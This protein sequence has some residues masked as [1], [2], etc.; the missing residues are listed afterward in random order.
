MNGSTDTKGLHAAITHAV[1]HY[2][3]I[4]HYLVT[5]Q[6]YGIYKKLFDTNKGVMYDF[7]QALKG[8]REWNKSQIDSVVDDIL[9]NIDWTKEDFDNLI[10]AIFVGYSQML[11]SVNLK[12][13]PENFV[14]RVPSHETFLHT[15]MVLSAE[16]IFKNPFIFNGSNDEKVCACY[17]HVEQIIHKSCKTAIYT[18]LPLKPILHYSNKETPPTKNV[19]ADVQH[20]SDSDDEDEYVDET[21]DNDEGPEQIKSIPL[22]NSTNI[23]PQSEPDSNTMNISDTNNLRSESDSNNM[24]ISDTTNVQSE[25]DSNNVQSESDSNIIAPRSES[26]DYNDE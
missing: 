8:I 4:L 2:I 25:S 18:L 11:T 16:R 3:D 12:Y 17:G 7:Q 24:N 1:D 13:E 20:E 23:P 15:I 26:N 14:L 6:L 22:N 10:T 9:R 19:S 5:D 21:S